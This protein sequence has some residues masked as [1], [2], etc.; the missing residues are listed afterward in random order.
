MFLV[1]K[2]VAR[3]VHVQILL[4]DGTKARVAL[5]EHEADPDT[6]EGEIA[7][8]FASVGQ[9]TWSQNDSIARRRG[10]RRS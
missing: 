1:D 4:E 6:A 3:R 9:L 2:G 7:D 5:V 10:G 8:F